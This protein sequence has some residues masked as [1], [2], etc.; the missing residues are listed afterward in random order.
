MFPIKMETLH[1]LEVKLYKR[2]LNI[3]IINLKNNIEIQSGRNAI[4]Y[5][6]VRANGSLN[7]KNNIGRN[8]LMIGKVL[9]LVFIKK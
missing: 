7:I 6:L 3:L 4:F 5:S 8:A 1:W 9:N 2:V